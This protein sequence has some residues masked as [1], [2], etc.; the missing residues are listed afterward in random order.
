MNMV[1]SEVKKE[2]GEELFG[3]VQAVADSVTAK[4]LDNFQQ[5]SPDDMGFDGPEGIDHED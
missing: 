5:I 1:N 3:Q 2:L 4:T